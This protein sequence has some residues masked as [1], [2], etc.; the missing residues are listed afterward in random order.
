MRAGSILVRHCRGQAEFE[1]CLELQV[2]V[3][4]GVELDV[5]PL[6]VFVI[7]PEMGGHVLGAFDGDRMIGFTLAFA[8]LHGLQPFLHSHMT[9]V[10]EPYRD[11]GVGRQLK[12]FQ[13]QDALARGIHLVEWTFDPLELRNAH[14]NIERLGAIVRRFLPNHYG[15][16]SSPLHA[17]LPTDRLLAE[18]HLKSPRAEA[19][20]AGRGL[21]AARHPQAQRIAVPGNIGE[22][23]RT[24]AA[25]AAEIQSHAREEFQRWLGQD[26]VVT[27]MEKSGEG[28]S[29]ILEPYASAKDLSA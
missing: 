4:G 23:K 7:T 12:M 29:Y 16:T 11:R 18:W 25:A 28:A 14:F 10:L 20:A 24:D 27:G 8:G 3:W 1:R 5:V 6:P 17:G 22:L 9:A 21:S 19:C 15:I 13:R 26:Y 2:A